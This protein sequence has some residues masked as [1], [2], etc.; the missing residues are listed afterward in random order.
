MEN[1]ISIVNQKFQDTNLFFGFD[2]EINRSFSL[3]VEYN[4]AM[5]DDGKEDSEILL[6]DKKGY[7]NAGLR[8]A[9]MANIMLEINVNDI[10]KNNISNFRCL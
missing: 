9:A 2:K 10:L 6:R 3:L 7:L 8:W 1:G 4:F 5:N